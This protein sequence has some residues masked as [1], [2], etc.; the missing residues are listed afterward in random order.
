MALRELEPDAPLR[1]KEDQSVESIHEHIAKAV[2]NCNARQV[3]TYIVKSAYAHWMKIA[4][5]PCSERTPGEDYF[6]DHMK[7]YECR[8]AL[9]RGGINADGALTLKEQLDRVHVAE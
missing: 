8:F 1:C 3:R 6:I 2:A 5:K 7:T 9:L 4:S